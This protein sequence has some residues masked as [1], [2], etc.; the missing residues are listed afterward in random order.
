[1]VS[2]SK[3]WSCTTDRKPMANLVVPLAQ[4][5]E[6]L[7]LLVHEHT[8]KVPSLCCPDLNCFVPPAHYLPSA[9][10]CWNETPRQLIKTSISVEKQKTKAIRTF[11]WWKPKVLRK[12]YLFG[13]T[14]KI[15]INFYGLWQ[16]YFSKIFIT[17][18]MNID[19]LQPLQKM[20]LLRIENLT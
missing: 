17:H 5:L 13:Q 3:K 16:C 8:V 12:H 1:M 4:E 15:L 6:F 2:N 14:K 9:D 11:I 19:F 10:V 7:G 20:S 18:Y